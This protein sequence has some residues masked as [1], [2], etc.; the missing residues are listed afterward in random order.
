MISTTRVVRDALH[1]AR[2]GLFVDFDGTLAP[3]VADP[4]AARPVR[5]ARGVLRALVDAGVTVTVL[6][7]RP[8]AFLAR[9][10]AVPGVTYAGLYGAEER[11]GRTRWTDPAVVAA[12]PAIVAAVAILRKELSELHIE[13]KGFAVAAHARRARD[14][15]AELQR[16][17]PVMRA[18]AYDLG[19]GPVTPGRLVLEIGASGAPTKG[20]SLARIVARER[21]RRVVVAGDDASDLAMFHA[22]RETATTSLAIWV[23]NA[24]VPT[25]LRTE[26][27]LTVGGPADLVA[28]LRDA[29]S[30]SDRAAR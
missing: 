10:L 22:A 26:A 29:A 18:V 2:A 7:G 25:T 21:L 4:A 8:V 24:E 20:S 19:L 13:D 9:T 28:V 1:G 23:E 3:I 12:R 6:S 16:A 11:R 27:D 17:R 5:G 14:P 30:R 15:V